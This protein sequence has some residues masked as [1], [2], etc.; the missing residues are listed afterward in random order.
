M[1]DTKNLV[2]KLSKRSKTAAAQAT[3]CAVGGVVHNN[4][5]AITGITP[6]SSP[7]AR[8]HPRKQLVIFYAVMCSSIFYLG[9]HAGIYMS[10][11]CYS[12]SQFKG[13]EKNRNQKKFNS[14]TTSSTIPS[15]GLLLVFELMVCL[16]SV[17]LC[18]PDYVFHVLCLFMPF[19]KF[20]CFLSFKFSVYLM[21]VCSVFVPKNY[22]VQLIC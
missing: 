9:G 7:E 2:R 10:T 17:V 21:L 13:K 5:L 4:S 14:N 8:E 6:T 11:V 20:F 16:V 12:C 18:F 3:R 15:V 1:Q 19:S 22:L